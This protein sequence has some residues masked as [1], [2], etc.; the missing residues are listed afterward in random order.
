LEQF[1]LRFLDKQN[2]LVLVRRVVARNDVAA[3][4]EANSVSRTHTLE[5]WQDE[6]LVGRVERPI[7]RRTFSQ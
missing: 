3:M 4:A 6:R 5:V 1:E 7:S 2:A